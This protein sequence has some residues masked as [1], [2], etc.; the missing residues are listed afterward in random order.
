M[1]RARVLVLLA[2]GVACSAVTSSLGGRPGPDTGLVRGTRPAR[3]AGA[4][5]ADRLTDGI[6]A[7]PGDPART[8]LTAALAGSEAFV[9]YDL[10]AVVPIR[11]ALL[12]ADG[13]DTYL[14]SV[15]SDGERFAP[16]WS[17]GAADERGM[18]LRMRRDLAGAGRYLRLTASGG[19]GV[20][21]IAELA[22]FSVCPP[23]WPPVLAVQRGTLVVESLHLKIWAL[24]ALAAAFALAYR[25]RAP[26]FVKLLVAVPLGV[27]LSLV[28]QL[29]EVWPPPARLALE[30]A[31]AVVALAGI[32][33][34]RL[35]IARRRPPAAAP[36][37]K[38][39]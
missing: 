26:D 16:L 13:D 3:S 10:G 20:Y 33:A 8:D 35:L 21:A 9:V 22:V 12:E 25:R 23:R 27:A 34:V 7:Y 5:H 30:L 36:V 32:V 29:A 6:A 4:R 17:A 28:L 19:D 14:L 39:S 11:C 38:E 37:R 15:S 18:Q 24:V 31:A 2:S 1:W